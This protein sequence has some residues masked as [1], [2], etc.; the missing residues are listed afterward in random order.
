MEKLEAIVRF[1]RVPAIGEK[2]KQ[3]GIGNNTIS[4]VSGWCKKGELHLRWTGRSSVEQPFNIATLEKGEN[5]V[6]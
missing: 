2:L 1:E 3:V 5:V 6:I 4:P